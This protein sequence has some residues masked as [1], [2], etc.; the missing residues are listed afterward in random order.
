ML[1]IFILMGMRVRTK[2]VAEGRFTCPKCGGDRLYH[3]KKAV[4][5]F[6]LYFIP[7]IP[8]GS[9]GEFVECQTCLTGFEM[10]VLSYKPTALTKRPLAQVMNQLDTELKSGTPIEY[11]IRDLTL[12]GLD[13]DVAK[14]TIRSHLTEKRLGCSD[15]GLTY[16]ATAIT[17][18]GCGKPLDP[19]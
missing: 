16:I 12:A 10:G 3:H 6:T 9:A 19:A 2:V 8:L 13:Q 11:V 14:N 17:C 1:P 18:R 5:W 15:C 7:V 4:R